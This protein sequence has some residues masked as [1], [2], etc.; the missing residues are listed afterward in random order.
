MFHNE[1]WRMRTLILLLA[2]GFGIYYVNKNFFVSIGNVDSDFGGGKL[3]VSE[4]RQFYEH[5]HRLNGTSGVLSS[6][7]LDAAAQT[8]SEQDALSREHSDCAMAST[9]LEAMEPCKVTMD[10]RGLGPRF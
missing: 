3:S 7:T 9:S 6:E 4:C 1:G 10:F 5:I 2:I 8:C